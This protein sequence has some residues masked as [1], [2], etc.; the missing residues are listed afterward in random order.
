[1]EGVFPPMMTPFRENERVD[2]DMFARNIE[3][4]NREKLAG[5]V[6]LGSNSEASYLS[7][8]EKLRLIRLT[9]ESS[10]KE[11]IVI[12][13]TGL[14]SARETVRFTQKAAGAGID[15]A[16]VL[17]PSYYI[18]Q[19]TDKALIDH[20]SFVADHSPVPILIYNVPKFTH[21]NVSL[22]VVKELSGHGNIVGIKDSRGDIGQLEEFRKVAPSRFHVMAGTA[23][24]WYPSLRF[25]VKAG[26]LALS[27]FAGNL[28]ARLQ[29]LHELGES[30]EAEE[31]HQRLLP[32]N[33]AVTAQYGVPG[34]KY[35]ATLA[36]Y[37]GGCVRRPLQPL[38]DNAKKEI[39]EILTKAGIVE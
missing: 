14:E 20:F 39:R 27:N 12:A 5:Y 38:D 28:C 21:I 18:G 15:A 1:M 17:T 9:K 10:K 36:G 37:E 25:G 30:G 26:I 2:Y 34:L 19:M 3:R 8:P 33:A 13:G 29:S 16:L 32:V 6:V 4:W 7:E 23:S 31:L 22:M 11:R 35:A 24:V